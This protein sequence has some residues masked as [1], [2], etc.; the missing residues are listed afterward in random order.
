MRDARGAVLALA[1]IVL[2]AAPALGQ[3]PAPAQVNVL[4]RSPDAQT[5]VQIRMVP[6]E[7]PVSLN[8]P[9]LREP[10]AAPTRPPA[11][12]AAPPGAS[13]RPAVVSPTP[14]RVAGPQLAKPPLPLAAGKT[15]IAPTAPASAVALPAKTPT[16]LPAAPI[17]AALTAA[18]PGSPPPAFLSASDAILR[19][20]F[21]EI[22]AKSQ[23][24]RHDEAQ[25][26]L[27]KLAADFPKADVA[28]QALF[29]AARLE[30]ANAGNRVAEF[31]LLIANYPGSYWATCSLLE[32][33]RTESLLGDFEPALAAYRAYQAQGGK[34][35]E[36]PSVHLDVVCCLL[37]LGRYAEA[38][39]ELDRLA[40][41]FPPERGAERVLD[42]RAECLMALGQ[43]DDAVSTL[44]TLLSNYP[45]YAL[46]P[47]AMLSL[48]LCLEL[49]NKTGEARD[50][51]G[52][53]VRLY[54]PGRADTP[55]ETGA[56]AQRLAKMNQPLFAQ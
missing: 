44:R 48:A 45:N 1:L 34:A 24:G 54:P 26:E 15:P 8:L 49:T 17:T 35:A 31:Q 5:T 38:L 19:K 50:V 9:P 56:A 11:Q 33:G 32:I 4:P 29:E 51:L 41:A 25:R 6:P 22:Q 37:P 30:K 21:L 52:Q 23:R 55:F 47:K 2:G 46:V 36:Q 12:L 18:L 13:P 53:I 20:R 14:P 27:R 10:A 42:L 40:A 28:P 3:A 7:R 16:P 39:K 43:Y